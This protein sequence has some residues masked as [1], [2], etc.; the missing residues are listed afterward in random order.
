MTET[1]FVHLATAL[2]HNP[3]ILAELDAPLAAIQAMLD[4]GAKGPE[5]RLLVA[6]VEVCQVQGSGAL[7]YGLSTA[8][9]GMA[10]AWT[11][12]QESKM[13]PP[14]PGPAPELTPEQ[15]SR[16]EELAATLNDRQFTYLTAVLSTYVHGSDPLT[17]RGARQ[18][19]ER[20]ERLGL[21]AIL[22]FSTDDSHTK[23]EVVVTDEGLD[24]I[25][26]RC[27][28]LDKP[29]QFHLTHALESSKR[30]GRLPRG[31]SKRA[32]A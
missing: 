20:L 18:A 25:I 8:L 21:V 22:D 31:D 14:P 19:Y 11:T 3:P 4:G 24:V 27:T 10:L 16:A 15:R 23:D 2:D 7:V 5:R 12:L 13:V 28:E 1:I 32:P 26:V 30:Q 17:G 9:R 6:A 29:H